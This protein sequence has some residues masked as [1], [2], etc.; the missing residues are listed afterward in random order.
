MRPSYLGNYIQYYLIKGLQLIDVCRIQ[1][2][3]SSLVPAM[4]A[5][6]ATRYTAYQVRETFAL[7]LS[8][9]ECGE[10]LVTLRVTLIA[11]RKILSQEAQVLQEPHG[12]IASNVSGNGKIPFLGT[13]WL[14]VSVHNV[15]PER[16]KL[17]ERLVYFLAVLPGGTQDQSASSG[18]RLGQ[19]VYVLS[20]QGLYRCHVPKKLIQFIGKT[21]AKLN[22]IGVED[23]LRA[24]AG[25]VRCPSRRAEQAPAGS[26]DKR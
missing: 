10:K 13:S 26:Q 16:V 20:Q 14:R 17:L 2:D 12:D 4:L 9:L 11:L 6:K 1:K 25:D 22:T 21:L 8:H 18:E 24:K 5:W 19:C 3:I 23:R 15:R 7:I